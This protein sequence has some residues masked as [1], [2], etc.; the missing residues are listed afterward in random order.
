V[1]SMH[2]D[3][4]VGDAA[5]FRR[6]ADTALRVARTHHRLVTVGMVPSRPDTGYGY[7]IPGD[8]LGDS[9]RA[10]ARFVEKPDAATALD[11]MADGALWNSGLFAWTGATLVEEIER[12]TPEIGR[13]L[14]RLHANDVAGF[15]REVT[16][17]SID[18]GLLER[19]AAVAVVSGAFAWDDVGTWDAL[20]RVRPK[21]ADGNV[22]VGRAVAQDSHDCVVWADQDAVVLY[23]VRDL[24]VVRAN[25]RVLVMPR[26]RAPQMKQLL[27]ALPPDVRTPSE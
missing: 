16:A 6:T 19:S 26:D 9:A 1:L 4:A 2:A 3:W 24:V 27:D 11:L 18:V 12:H 17:V 25:G 10:V 21:D 14:P 7:I 13:H 5:E 20:G 22:L 23:G 8:E 15:F